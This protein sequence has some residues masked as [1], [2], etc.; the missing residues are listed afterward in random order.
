MTNTSRL[1]RSSKDS[2]LCG[3]AGGMAEY[4][5]I[6]V[7]LMRVAWV[8]FVLATGGTALLA[9]IILAVILPKDES[10][11]AEPSGVIRENLESLPDDTAIEIPNE[12][13]GTTAAEN[14]ERKARRRNLLALVLIIVGFLV[15]LGNL[16]FFDFLWWWRWDL[17]WPLVIIAIGVALLV[18][19]ARSR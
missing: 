1:H 14:G 11:T 8:L 19:R 5:D 18:S 17:L 13:T 10:R 9:Y 3:V 4:F 12:I 15:L 6:D 2:M 7:A 16:D